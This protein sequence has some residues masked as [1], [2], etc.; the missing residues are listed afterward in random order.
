VAVDAGMV[1]PLPDRLSFAA[2][3]G[4]PMNYLTVHFGLLRRGRLQAGETVLV[5]GAAGGVGSAAIQLASA[6]GARV[7]GVVST[8]AKADVARRAGAGDVVPADGFLPAVRELTS[9]APPRRWPGSPSAAPP[10]R[11]S[12]RCEIRWRRLGTLIKIDNLDL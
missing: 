10:A 12:S 3:A 11:S 7:I 2:G 5:H 1:F 6:L 9:I 4:L 8:D